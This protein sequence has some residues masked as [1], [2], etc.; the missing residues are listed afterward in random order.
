MKQRGQYRA[1][2]VYIA[3]EGSD[4][5]LS[6]MMM[7]PK[8]NEKGRVGVD[9]SNPKRYSYFL[10][11]NAKTTT[12]QRF[13]I[14]N[15]KVK[16]FDD[17][18]SRFAIEVVDK[19]FFNS[20]KQL[21]LQLNQHLQED[22]A[23]KIFAEKQGIKT[24]IFAKK[25]LGQIVFIYFLQ[26]KGWLGAKKNE[27]INQGD[28]HFLRN[29][30][31]KCISDG[32][33]YYN[34]CLEY[35]FY[36]CLNK[37]P[38]K[39]ASFYRAH[40]DCQIPFLN[41]GLFEPIN[42]YDWENEFLNIPNEI[43][44][45]NPEHPEK[46]K[47]ILD[48]FDLYNFTVD[49]N[50]PDDQEVS[51][52]PEMLGKVFENLLETNIR[53]GSG[54]YYT[55]R[56]I[57]H[58]MCKESLINYLTSN[59]DISEDKA[60]MIITRDFDINFEDVPK[61]MATKSNTP[62]KSLAI[63]EGDTK[64]LSNLL[65]N[66][67]IVDPACGSG[68]FLVGMLQQI[69]M[70]RSLMQEY[71]DENLSD[72]ELKKQTIQNCIYGVDIDPGAIDIAKL[73]LWLS[74]VVDHEIDDIEPLPNLDYKIMQGNSLLE[75][76]VVGDSV[77]PLKFNGANRLDGRTKEMKNLFEEEKQG[78]LIPDK[79]ETL[80]DK[81]EKYHNQ[82]FLI[83]DPHEK[84]ILKNKIDD[85][86]DQLIQ[87]KCNEELVR[88]KEQATNPVNSKKITKIIEQ[89]M[90]IRGT[91][92]QWKKDHLRPFFP[93]K[94]HFSDVFRDKGGFDV[95]IANPPY[96]VETDNSSAFQAVKI[97][98]FGKRYYEG[99]MDFFYFFIEKS[100]IDLAHQKTIISFIT[101]N[102]WLTSN[103]AKKLRD[104][105][106]TFLKFVTIINFNEIKIFDTAQGQH[107]LVFI[108]RAKN[109]LKAVD[110]A[111]NVILI[112]KLKS[113]NEYYLDDLCN[114]S[115]SCEG[116][117]KY[118]INDLYD[119]NNHLIAI[120]TNPEALQLK[121]KLQENCIN[122]DNEDIGNGIDILQEN[123]TKKHNDLYPELKIGEGVF[124]LSRREVENLGLNE[125]EYKA[126]KPFYTMDNLSRYCVVKKSNYFLIYSNKL[127]LQ[128]LSLYPNLKK[129]LDKFCY[130]MTSV[131]KPYGLNRPRDEYYFT[132][133]KLLVLRMTNEP[134]FSYV[135]GDSYVS[136]TFLIIKSRKTRL[137]LKYLSA[138]FN[139]KLAKFWFYNFGKRKGK[140]LQIDKE[141]LLHF[142]IKKID[143][144]VES[145]FVS[146]FD[147]IVKLNS[148]MEVD[149]L[150]NIKT[151]ED[152]IDSL[153]FKIYELDSKEIQI[154][155]ESIN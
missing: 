107:N 12:P 144:K 28:S 79:S 3:S 95:V 134:V 155:K 57:V 10:G 128:N 1:L 126:I 121:K 122:L 32:K 109:K 113:G 8:V 119:D 87:S 104:F 86:E 48:I 49:E 7:D 17:L 75:D 59:I 146:I 22:H 41:G 140:L 68:A 84:K 127:F 36:D 105:T 27:A 77:I 152:K 19:E 63:W 64:E 33:N 106:K 150:K 103:G 90:A 115:S 5:R 100:S 39:A 97:T 46:G 129:H 135:I 21:F 133:E 67:K 111:T 14:K 145:E 15:G 6:L 101:T 89:Q 125:N 66:I 25:L 108:S 53:K 137:N 38:E 50:T 73:R 23:F 83:N 118:Q 43:F 78:I 91:L 37:K 47:G 45:D 71:T 116:V 44:S 132:G 42:N 142:P 102:Y 80:A 92:D 4:W 141:P 11:E 60:R 26:R 65:K 139:S 120:Q 18:K 62:N 74:L 117:I 24:E 13:L 98:D 112:D 70:A 58:Y 31:T 81:L 9:F 124:V 29:Q 123:V 55:P 138:L 72:Y 130:I 110:N 16:D 52:D 76:L 149:T 114:N 96:F 82:Y 93:W 147:N 69:V 35:L 143:K 40:F 151:L 56:E 20:Y 88:L 54:S 99:R 85:I 131:N 153:V 61:V 51:V 148:A 34:D 30:L 94:L 154:I 136:R 2:F